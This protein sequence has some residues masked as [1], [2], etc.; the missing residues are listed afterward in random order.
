MGLCLEQTPE[1]GE[2]AVETRRESFKLSGP[3]WLY[4]NSDQPGGTAEIAYEDIP[5]IRA[6]LD[7]IEAKR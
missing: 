4:P 2:Y 5:K 6:C 1:M 7:A 3:M